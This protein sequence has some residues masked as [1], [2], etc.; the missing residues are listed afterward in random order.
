MPSPEPQDRAH[1]VREQEGRTGQ[2]PP[3]PGPPYRGFG[4]I[5][6]IRRTLALGEREE[7]LVKRVGPDLLPHV[8]TWVDAFYTRLLTD[9]AAMRILDDDARVIRLKR[10]L[11]AWFHDFFTLPWDEEYE[12]TREVIGEAHVR[13]FMPTQ[14]MTVSMSRLRE[15][16]CATIEQIWDGDPEEAR[17]ISRTVARA[18]DMEL[19]IMLLAFRRSERTAAREKDRVVYAQRAAH[20]LAQTLYDRVDAALCYAKLA[21]T[22]DASRQ[23]YLAKLRDTLKGLTRQDQRARAQAGAHV[24]PP[25]VASLSEIC[26]GALAD[27]SL[28][29][30]TRLGLRVEPLGLQARIRGQAVRLAIE[31]LVQ[32]GARHAAGGLIQV[33]VKADAEGRIVIEVTDEGAG[34][35]PSVKKFEDIYNLGTGLGLSFCE[36]V[37]EL[38]GGHIELFAAPTGGAGV[39]LV[40]RPAEEA[41]A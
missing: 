17:E 8:P 28:D 31:E 20:R 7:A 27:V 13:I 30:N 6:A 39:R 21:D 3:V 1:D 22:D 19:T 4:G 34:W 24:L 38:H 36:L 29:R 5:A 26:R 41:G 14:L 35:D 18:L 40:L 12:R 23:G 11:I 33:E 2:A 16:V 25:R 32:N 37:A 10:S 9:P 15:D